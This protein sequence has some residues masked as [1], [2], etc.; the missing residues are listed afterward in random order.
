MD[1][2][3]VCTLGAGNNQRAINGCNSEFL[4]ANVPLLRF[5][6][7]EYRCLGFV[8]DASQYLHVFVF[9]YHQTLLVN[10]CFAEGKRMLR[11]FLQRKVRDLNAEMGN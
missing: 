10:V 7:G 8:L 2:I 4:A 3:L 5:G 1:S 6:Q 11:D 9:F